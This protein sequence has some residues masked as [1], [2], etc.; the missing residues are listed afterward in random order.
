MSGVPV[1]DSTGAA[2]LKRLAK[3]AASKGTTIILSELGREPGNVLAGLDVVLPTAATFAESLALARQMLDRNRQSG[4][5]P[6]SLVTN[7]G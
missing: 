5:P 4:V 3:G 2:A 6:R 1:I 7:S